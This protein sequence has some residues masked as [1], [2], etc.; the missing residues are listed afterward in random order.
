MSIFRKLSI[1]AV[2]GMMVLGLAL[3]A[4]A[5]DEKKGMQWR[6]DFQTSFGQLSTSSSGDAKATVTGAELFTGLESNLYFSGGSGE[7]TTDARWRIRGVDRT[8]W[9]ATQTGTTGTKSRGGGMTNDPDLNDISA[10]MTSALRLWVN[11]RPV[12]N[13][14]I[15]VGRLTTVDI[16]GSF[17]SDIDNGQQPIRVQDGLVLGENADGIDV[18]YKMGALTAGL[19]IFSNCAGSTSCAGGLSSGTLYNDQTLM[20]H[21]GY[22]QG[23]I[24][25]SARYVMASGSV[26]TT[27]AG[28]NVAPPSS[29]TSTVTT[30]SV[31]SSMLHV[32]G[33]FDMG[34]GSVSADIQ[35]W[36]MGIKLLGEGDRERSVLGLALRTKMGVEVMYVTDAAVTKKCD[37]TGTATTA[38]T[39]LSSS[40][41]VGESKFDTAVLQVQYMM[42][43]GQG[44]WG[45][46]FATESGN[47]KG[48][49]TTASDDW[50]VTATTIGA[51]WKTS[52]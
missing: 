4:S 33:S 46:V 15:Q 17:F 50:K 27:G 23:P 9:G 49:A 25:F 10:Y 39:C 5:Q 34:F 43:A 44:V 6:G 51:V 21:V 35:T 36:T 3:T 11:W 12:E 26:A 18:T 8:L 31:S 20:P 38:P 22:V 42:K 30:N 29:G 13:L 37:I 48:G 24:K 32:G 41:Q 14:H 40:A 19:G 47:F 52:L 16:P 1:V 45:P 28:L 2:A 7:L